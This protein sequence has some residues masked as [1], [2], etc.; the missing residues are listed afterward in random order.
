MNKAIPNFESDLQKNTCEQSRQ[1]APQAM[2]ILS[3]QFGG[4][5]DYAEKNFE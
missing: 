1:G 2:S 5:P 4:G 3:P